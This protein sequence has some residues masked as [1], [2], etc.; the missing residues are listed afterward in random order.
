MA[1][2][3]ATSATLP[4]RPALGHPA[5]RLLAAVGIGAALLPIY[6]EALQWVVRVM[7]WSRG[8]GL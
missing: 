8:L 1:A 4:R 2:S 5:L 7:D 3:K 6:V